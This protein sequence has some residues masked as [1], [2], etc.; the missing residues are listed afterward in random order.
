MQRTALRAAADAERWAAIAANRQGQ[1]FIPRILTS[2][3]PRDLL[4][5]STLRRSRLAVA[6]RL[7]TAGEA[8]A[9]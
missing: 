2:L 7:R 6:A 1:T 9:V 8:N 3:H 4:P 5:P